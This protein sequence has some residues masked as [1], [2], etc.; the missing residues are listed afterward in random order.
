MQ[1]EDMKTGSSELQSETQGTG[2][3]GSKILELLSPPAREAIRLIIASGGESK[4]Q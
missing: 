2:R 1:P 4:V 3:D